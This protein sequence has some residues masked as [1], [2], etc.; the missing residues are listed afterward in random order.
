MALLMPSVECHIDSAN[1][2]VSG[3]TVTVDFDGDRFA[4]QVRVPRAA[5]GKQFPFQLSLS[6]SEQ[7]KFSVQSIWPVAK[8][9]EGLKAL[10]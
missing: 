9:P 6:D 10:Q 4:P 7:I 1:M 2:I 8:N 3:H 5:V